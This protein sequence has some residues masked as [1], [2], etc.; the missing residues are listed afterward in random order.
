[1]REIKGV[2]TMGQEKGKEVY[3]WKY[4]VLLALRG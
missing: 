4:L 2:K 3:R 1:M